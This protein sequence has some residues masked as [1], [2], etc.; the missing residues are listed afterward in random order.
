VIAKIHE[1][2]FTLTYSRSFTG[3]GGAGLRIAELTGQAPGSDK[4]AYDVF[5]ATEG[6]IS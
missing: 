6:S 2:I 4:Q 5:K 3:S 1:A